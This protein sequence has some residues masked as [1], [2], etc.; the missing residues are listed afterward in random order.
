MSCPICY[1][2]VSDNNITL[3]HLPC[4]H[5]TCSDCLNLWRI[6]SN[7]CPIC[8]YN[9]NHG[10]I[11]FDNITNQ[12]RRLNMTFPSPKGTS[13]NVTNYELNTL[14]RIFGN[15][16]E[17]CYDNVPNLSIGSKIL[18]QSYISNCWWYGR[19]LRIENNIIRLGDCIYNQ[20][21]NGDIYKSTPPIRDITYSNMDKFMILSQNRRY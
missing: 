11:L 1:E 8:R 16:N 5:S 3:V 17:I 14:R 7:D 12:P 4:Q 6:Q 10:E 20:R 15:F 18:I 9:L 21:S 19:I 2:E 13:I